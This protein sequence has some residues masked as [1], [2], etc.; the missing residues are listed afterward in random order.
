MEDPVRRSR[1]GVGAH[2]YQMTGVEIDTDGVADRVAQPEE[3][4]DAVDVLVP[5]Q[6]EAELP[7][8]DALGISDKLLPIRD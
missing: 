6:F 5:M 3:D 4:A 8:A 7:D 1:R 2:P